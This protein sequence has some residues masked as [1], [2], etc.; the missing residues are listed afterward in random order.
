M[1]FQIK[2]D[3]LFNRPLTCFVIIYPNRSLRSCRANRWKN[4]S[5]CKFARVSARGILSIDLINLVLPL[6]SSVITNKSKLSEIGSRDIPSHKMHRMYRIKRLRY[7]FGRLKFSFLKIASRALTIIAFSFLSIQK[8]EDKK[9]YQQ[10][11]NIPWHVTVPLS[12]SSSYRRIIICI[13]QLYVIDRRRNSNRALIA[14]LLSL[15]AGDC[16][17]GRYRYLP[18]KFPYA[19]VSSLSNLE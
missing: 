14:I 18:H 5:A 12:I 10:P 19:R 3:I 7:F 2:T 4:F 15:V 8:S 9:F 16:R 17:R 6:W 13:L 11:S 1:L